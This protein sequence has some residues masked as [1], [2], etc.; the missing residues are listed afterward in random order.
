[1]KFLCRIVRFLLEFPTIGR[2]D[3]PESM[4]KGIEFSILG[5]DGYWV[6]LAYYHLKFDR[7]PEIRVGNFSLL[8]PGT[9]GIRGYDVPAHSINS[10]IDSPFLASLE[11]CDPTYLEGSHAQ[12]RWLETSRHPMSNTVPVDVWGLDNVTIVQVSGD[13]ELWLVDDD[14]DSQEMLK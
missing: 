13:S 6:P 14:F 12:F 7:R 2:C 5:N 8:S 1:M 3:A 10:S 4:D 9:V 11:I